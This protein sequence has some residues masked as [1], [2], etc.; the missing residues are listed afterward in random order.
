MCIGAVQGKLYPFTSFNFQDQRPVTQ[1]PEFLKF[2]F[3][4]LKGL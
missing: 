3:E 1:V 4:E 2:M